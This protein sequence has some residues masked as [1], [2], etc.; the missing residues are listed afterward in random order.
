[1]TTTNV[2][3]QGG[4]QILR[5]TVDNLTGEVTSRIV[6]FAGIA[7]IRPDDR[8]GTSDTGEPDGLMFLRIPVNGGVAVELARSLADGHLVTDESGYIHSDLRGSVVAKTA[9][10]GPAMFDKAAEYD[11]WGN[12]VTLPGLGTP[13]H[14]FVDFE[15]DQATGYYYMGARVYDPTL[16]R[17][18]SP[19]PLIFAV[20]QLE[21]DD[22]AGLNLLAYANNN[23][24]GL[25]DPSGTQ[26]PKTSMPGS[27]CSTGE[28]DCVRN[29][30][31]GV[32]V[33][34]KPTR[35]TT[36]DRVVIFGLKVAI[37]AAIGPM[38]DFYSFVEAAASGNG[39]KMAMVGGMILLNLILDHA[40]DDMRMTGQTT[41][42]VAKSV[43]KTA[44]D[45]YISTKDGAT[46]APD[47]DHDLVDSSE[48]G[49]DW[50]Q[51]HR[52]HSHG[53]LTNPHTHYPEDNIVDGNVVSRTRRSR[54]TTADDI[55]NADNALKSGKMRRRRNRSDR[56]GSTE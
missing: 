45:A 15:P 56:G 54:E 30:P 47:Q 32:P 49:G 16:R 5:K 46:L 13:R 28:A 29:I 36:T 19:D 23:P 11:A 48:E 7:E 53:D 50:L 35:L 38:T 27:D 20:P 25:T 26:V 10:D 24:V 14:Q 1:M 39:E 8:A 44:D 42:R 9:I 18:L 52:K 40:A 41:K 55:N 43:A 2:C 34:V 6:D 33:G 51:I 3:G 37:N 17:W 22:G 21:Q 4:K 31:Q 12:T